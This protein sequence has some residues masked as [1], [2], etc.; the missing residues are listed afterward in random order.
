MNAGICGM[1]NLEKLPARFEWE[2]NQMQSC[3]AEK[4][5]GEVGMYHVENMSLQQAKEIA[6]WKYP[7]P[8]DVYN[9]PAWDAMEEGK[10]AIT[11]PERRKQ[12]FRIICYA[13]E[14]VAYFRLFKTQ[15]DGK[16]FLGLGLLPEFCGKGKGADIVGQILAYTRQRKI[17]ALYL[18]VRD[19]NKRAIRCYQKA[20]FVEVN[21][22]DKHVLGS[23]CRMIEM[24]YV[25]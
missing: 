6:E 23:V 18:E 4:K 21:R 14:I 5:C 17:K 3:L 22:Y 8:Y 24:V 12:E 13:N 19:F 15:P 16:Y 11:L 25:F 2:E 20:G 7:S 1:F 10:W 9:F